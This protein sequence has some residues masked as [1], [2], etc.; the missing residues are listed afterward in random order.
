[1]S[2]GVQVPC[3]LQGHRRGGGPRGA[4]KDSRASEEGTVGDMEPLHIRKSAS[5][6]AGERRGPAEDEAEEAEADLAGM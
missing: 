6:E 5:R 4:G 2:G 3:T 1:M